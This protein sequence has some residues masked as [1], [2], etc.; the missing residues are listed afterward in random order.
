MLAR[1]RQRQ[2]VGVVLL[3]PALLT[4]FALIVYPLFKVAEYSI[5][6]GHTMNLSKLGTLPL[7]FDNFQRVLQ[8]D[9]FWHSILV[10]A[11]Y[12]V[13][14]VG[15]AFLLGLF[16]A[17]LL[18]APIPLRRLWRTIVLIPWAVPSVV[19]SIIFLWM[20]D[21]SFGV[22]NA[23]LRD[24]GLTATGLNWF[25]DNR[26][27]L[28][29]VI[30]PSVWKLYPL[31]TLTLLAVMQSIPEELY[32]A[33]SVDGCRGYRKFVHIT[34]P[35]IRGSALLICLIGALWAFRDIDIIYATTRGGPNRAT[36]TVALY[37]YNE[38]FQY[39]RMG[40]AAAAGVVMVIFAIVSTVVMIR[41]LGRDKF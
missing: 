14:T 24:L 27:A 19:A 33:A 39:L 34:W 6:V 29:A 1:D 35:G 16:S 21:G 20:L 25:L 11:G 8:D 18:N 13:G 28:I 37:V 9:A 2:L 41:V 31:F 15:G 4:L 22:V 30:V 12:V 3:A 32:E 40:S 7:G 38:A 17:L 36:E 26:T 23:I 5:R 10:S